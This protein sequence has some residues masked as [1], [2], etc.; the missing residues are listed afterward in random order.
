MRVLD[1]RSGAKVG[2]GG[3]VSVNLASRLPATATAVVFNLT[4][5][6]P[7]ASTYVTAF[8]HGQARPVVSNLNL[9]AGETRANLVTVMVGADRVVDLYNNSGS[10]HLLADL[11]GY[12]STDDTAKFVPMD[13]R[14][15]LSAHVGAQSTT[16]LDLTGLV[17]ASATAVTL[18]VTGDWGTSSTFVTAW[19]AGSPRPNASTVNL[20]PFETTPNMATVALGAGR[21]VNLYNHSGELDLSVDLGGFYTPAFG[22]VFVPVSP[23]RV[24]DTRSGTGTAWSGPIASGEHAPVQPGQHVPDDAVGAVL[25]VTGIAGVEGT[26][27]SVTEV[28]DSVG[29]PQHVHTQPGGRAGRGEPDRGPPA[30]REPGRADG[31]LQQRGQ[32]ARR[33]RPRGLLPVRVDA[34]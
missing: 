21:K 26:Y 27:L 5:V 17:P 15:V 19:P 6:Q 25:N 28:F 7:T 10:T 18:N 14:R 16:V 8:P 11:A 31:R 12:Y 3:V 30:A 23:V 29:P 34:V 32:R 13:A 9:R 22:S 33:R 4:G 1:T 20:A 2:A 24:F